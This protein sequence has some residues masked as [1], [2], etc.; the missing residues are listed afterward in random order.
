MKLRM[1]ALPGLLALAPLPAMAVDPDPQPAPVAV[2][3]SHLRPKL[4]ARV[5]AA[6]EGGT[7][8]LTQFLRRTRMIYNL[9][10]TEVLRPDASA[11]QRMAA[12]E[13]AVMTAQ[14]N[15][16]PEVAQASAPR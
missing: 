15:T 10:I 11:A 6:A 8:S 14:G 7:V 16:T 5:E 4:A 1:L 12:P 13:P 9:H 3:T 2:D